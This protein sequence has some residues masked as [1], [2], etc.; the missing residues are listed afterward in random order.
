MRTSTHAVLVIL[1][2]ILTAS[3]QQPFIL[4]SNYKGLN[5]VLPSAQ[6]FASGLNRA[7]Y[8]H[9]Q[10]VAV[11]D[12]KRN[13]EIHNC[14]IVEGYEPK[15]IQEILRNLSASLR[16]TE[17]SF[18]Q[19]TSLMYR[20]EEFDRLQPRLSGQSATAKGTFEK[21]N[22]FG[23]NALNLLSGILPGTKWCGTG[24]V[25]QDYHDLG[26][27]VEIDRCCRT[28]DLCP[29]KIRAHRTR[30]NLT[31]YSLYSKSHCACDIALHQCLKNVASP[32][33]KLMGTLY[34][35]VAKVQCVDDVP[36]RI[37]HGTSQ[38]R[39]SSTGLTF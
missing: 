27:E 18:D 32:T 24:D 15:E 37:H 20:C 29:V 3:T 8:F 39:F 31:N 13:N 9:E 21:A 16:P 1:G 30:Y 23:A 38:K 12:F 25:A 5:G 19:M 4:R 33:A 7:V 2:T 22:E 36:S 28:H 35:N 11:V 34:F 14:D 17:V 26:P 6:I 10:A